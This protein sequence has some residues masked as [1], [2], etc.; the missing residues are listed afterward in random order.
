MPSLRETW[1]HDVAIVLHVLQREHRAA[2][3]RVDGAVGQRRVADRHRLSQTVRDRAEQVQR[4]PR[5]VMLAVE[6]VV[7]PGAEVKTRVRDRLGREPP[8]AAVGH[9]HAE[10][11]AEQALV[12]RV[13]TQLRRDAD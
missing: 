6:A 10:L 9:L 1:L 7:E 13:E 11:A 3:L 5:A 8:L 2:A 4:P 12:L